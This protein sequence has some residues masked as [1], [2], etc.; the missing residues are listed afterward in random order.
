MGSWCRRLRDREV[1]IMNS[2]LGST[3]LSASFLPYSM[4]CF[5]NNEKFERLLQRICNIELCF[6]FSF[7]CI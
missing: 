6:L 7:Y 4:I 1:I 5:Y 3:T 2:F